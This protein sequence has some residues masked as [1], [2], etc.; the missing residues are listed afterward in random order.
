MSSEPDS[1]WTRWPERRAAELAAFA[2]RGAETAVR[3]EANG[4]LILDVKWAV[5]GRGILALRV[6]FSFLHPFFRPEV[7]A[8]DD[9]FGRHQNPLSHGLCLVAQGDNQWEAGELVADMIDRQ[10]AKLLSVLD[11]RDKGYLAKAANDEEQLAD[12]LSVYY[13]GLAERLSAA[14]I[15][16]DP[17]IPGERIGLANA[18]AT[19][20]GVHT[21]HGDPA[22]EIIVHQFQR[23]AGPWLAASFDLPQRGGNWSPLPA[24][25]V[26]IS[27][28]G[29]RTANDLMARACASATQVGPLAGSS[30]AAWDAVAEAAV[31]LTVCVVEDEANYTGDATRDGFICLLSRRT[32]KTVKHKVVRSFGIADDMFDRLP[33]RAGLREKRALLIGCGAI[34]NFVAMEL[35]RAGFKAITLYDPDN[36]EPGNYVRW[37]IG[38]GAWGVPKAFALASLI[39]QHFPWTKADAIL[40]K[41]GAVDSNPAQLKGL[42]HNPYRDLHNAIK[43]ADVVIDASASTE[44]QHAMAYLCKQA[45]TPLV[46]GYGTLGAAG[47]VVAQ[48]QA[49]TP[50]CFNCAKQQWKATGLPDPAVDESGTL[51]PVGCNAETFTGGSYDLQEVSLQ[52]VRSVIGLAI[53]ELFDPGDWDIAAISHFRDGK[54]VLPSWETARVQPALPCCNDLAAA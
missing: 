16:R 5:E 20:R 34:G 40:D 7:A 31:A 19:H 9:V 54:R 35:A 4:I 17:A 32:G 21:E 49:D 51:V 1:W 50:A 18:I 47:G 14:Y 46:I 43:D 26:R 2:R 48:F 3:Y 44:C 22:V 42:K 41:V 13:Q 6:G 25:W 30:I 23:A 11:A 24:R 10:L 53:P 29:C 45:R 52:M 8:P 38:R 33:V 39:T 28:E 36:V 37:T 15:A 27:V 12:P